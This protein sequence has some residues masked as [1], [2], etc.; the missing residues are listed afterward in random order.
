M[1]LASQRD[2]TGLY[3]TP[4]TVLNIS[5]FLWWQK[6]FWVQYEQDIQHNL[7]TVHNA[8]QRNII[9]YNPQ[10]HHH[11]H[12]S[13]PIYGYWIYHSIIV[14]RLYTT[15]SLNVLYSNHFRRH[16]SGYKPIFRPSCPF[17]Y[18]YAVVTLWSCDSSHRGA[19]V[20]EELCFYE[21]LSS[22]K[23]RNT[24]YPLKGL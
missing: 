9:I 11:H 19:Q 10:V 7:L 14:I 24:S 16:V 3:K 21:V 8:V 5:I 1:R 2:L 23:N 12:K 15:V 20:E 6:L 13:Q 22:L 17:P 18:Y 4:K